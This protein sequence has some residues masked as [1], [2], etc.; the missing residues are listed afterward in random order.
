MQQQGLDLID[1]I[2]KGAI[3]DL[4]AYCVVDSQRHRCIGAPVVAQEH[5]F[6]DSA[7]H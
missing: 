7:D 6:H 5:R 3:A 1:I 4:S 2:H